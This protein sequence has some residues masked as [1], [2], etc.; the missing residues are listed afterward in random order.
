MQL[1][2][3]DEAMHIDALILHTNSIA[4]W[5]PPSCCDLTSTAG[6]TIRINSTTRSTRFSAKWVPP[7]SNANLKGDVLVVTPL[8]LTEGWLVLLLKHSPSIVFT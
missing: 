3:V 8:Y 7:A 1:E 2:M 6:G 5:R 4:E